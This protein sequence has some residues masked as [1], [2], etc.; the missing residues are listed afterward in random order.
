MANYVTPYV[1]VNPRESM[2]RVRGGYDSGLAASS[3]YS[4]GD[5]VEIN[6]SGNVQKCTQTTPANI[7]PLGVVSTDFSVSPLDST[8]HAYWTDRGVPVDTL[9]ERHVVVFTYQDAT[10]DGSD[11][12]FQT[13]DLASVRSQEQ[14]ELIFNA[15]ENV[16]TIR[17]GTTNPNV[18]MLYV[19]EG[20]EVGDTNVRVACR[21]LDDFR[22]G[23]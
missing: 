22:L 16:L 6:G 21:I 8:R 3:Q 13:A 11:D 10:A 17:D 12:T 7:L 15:T 9:P 4:I 19:V 23:A 5:L 1:L 20:G 2:G 14:R 18:Q